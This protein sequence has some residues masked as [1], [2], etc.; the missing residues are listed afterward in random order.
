MNSPKKRLTVRMAHFKVANTV[1]QIK[2]KQKT[3][4]VRM[5]KPNKNTTNLDSACCTSCIFKQIGFVLQ[6]KKK[7]NAEV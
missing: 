5:F 6:T 3:K 4:F 1:Y 7:L 2:I